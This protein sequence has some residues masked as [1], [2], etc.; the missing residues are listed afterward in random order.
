M[1]MG[2]GRLARILA[3]VA[4]AFLVVAAVPQVAAADS[5]FKIRDRHVTDPAGMTSEPD[6]GHYWV[7][8]GGSGPVRAWAI[9]AKGVPQGPAASQNQAQNIQALAE[10]DRNLYLGDVGGLRQ[11]V[12][13]W[14]LRDPVPTTTVKEASAYR[15]SYP[16]GSHSAKA[17]MVDSRKRI[18]VVT[19]GEPGA[20]YRTPKSPSR[21]G[22]TQLE[23]IASAPNNVVDAVML[24]DGGAVMRSYTK[25]YFLDADWKVESTESIPDQPQGGALTLSLDGKSVVAAAGSGGTTEVFPLPQQPDPERPT[26]KP[27]PSEA[28]VEPGDEEQGLGAATVIPQTGTAVTIAAAMVVA[29]LAG[30]VVLVRR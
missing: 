30:L 24:P 4:A 17:I 6:R 5:G 27:K 20:I 29:V 8:S 2:S 12:T 22:T 3:G 28:E 25:L 1:G 16:D 21:E 19:V 13:V 11:T 7:V 26:Q 15:L 9:D 18:Y 10:R 14:R 23:K